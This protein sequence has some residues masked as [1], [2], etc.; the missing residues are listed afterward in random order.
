MIQWAATSLLVAMA[1][2]WVVWSILLPKSVRQMLRAR[3]AQRKAAPTGKAGCD[4][5]GSCH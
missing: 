3:F 2:F 5:G 4:C 1:A